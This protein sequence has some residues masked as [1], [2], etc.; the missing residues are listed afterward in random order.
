MKTKMLPEN[1]IAIRPTKTVYCADGTAIK[2]FSED[3]SK[4]DVLNEALN[5]ARV[6]ETGLP[7]PRILEVT[8]VDGKW[9]IV[10]EYIEGTLCIRDVDCIALRINAPK[11][12]L[13]KC[14]LLL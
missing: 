10:T 6:E 2:V 5:Q 14:C 3:Y 13:M 8:K 9:V 7:I 1:I 12:T 4:A 11:Q